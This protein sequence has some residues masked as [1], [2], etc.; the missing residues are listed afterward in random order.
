MASRRRPTWIALLR[1]VN[2]GRAKRVAMADLR[3][4]LEGLGCTEVRTLLN[5]GNVND[6]ITVLSNAASKVEKLHEAQNLL[7]VAYETKGMRD[8]AFKSF[9]LALKGV[10]KNAEY[11]NYIG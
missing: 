5:S 2:V 7:G 1:G 11:L 9:E 6:A 10:D 8:R 4:L 3:S